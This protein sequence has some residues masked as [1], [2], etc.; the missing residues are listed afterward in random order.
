MKELKL[1]LKGKAPL[2]MQSCILANP[3][4]PMSKEIKKIT[5]LRK[6]TD[7]DLEALLKLKFLGSIYWDEKL[8]P[9]IPGENLDRAYFDAAKEM[10]LGKKFT[11][12][13]LIVEDKLPL[14]YEGPREPEKLYDNLNFVDT[15]LVKIGTSRVAM[16]RPIF[17]IWALNA[18]LAFN[19]ELI[20]ERDVRQ[21]TSFVGRQGLGTFR[22]RFGKFTAEVA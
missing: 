8:G 6:K 22:R 9:F 15:R 19:E 4:H 5:G 11:Q 12:A 13:A 2:I 18:T 17:K 14:V 3:L 21:I 1:K 16:S 10:K 20:D 7:D